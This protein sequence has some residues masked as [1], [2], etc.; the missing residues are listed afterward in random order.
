MR[1]TIRPPQT[2][3][4]ICGMLTFITIGVRRPRE[5]IHETIETVSNVG[6]QR[7]DH[8]KL[9]RGHDELCSVQ[10]RKIPTW[11]RVW[12]PL[13]TSEYRSL[14][15]HAQPNV[16]CCVVGKGAKFSARMH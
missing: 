8:F 4:L 14:L 13:I 6:Q 12:M 11:Y 7:R 15:S 1:G 3:S 5:R 2:H 9:L 16:V 10:I